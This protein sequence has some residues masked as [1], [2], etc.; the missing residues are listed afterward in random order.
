MLTVALDHHGA[1]R[2]VVRG[3]YL[4][5][6]Q[7][8]DLDCD[9]P[10]RGMADQSLADLAVDVILALQADDPDRW[11]PQIEAVAQLGEWIRRHGG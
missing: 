7:G 10:S 8:V 5:S 11:E 9:V 4:V 2:R 6:H 3:P 1:Q